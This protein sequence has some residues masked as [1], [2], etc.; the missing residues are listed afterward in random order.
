MSRLSIIMPVLDEGEAIAAALDALADLRAL[1]AEVIVVDGG[2]RDATVQR[3]RL[4]A[5]QVLTAPRG[6]ASQMNAGAE[7]AAGD[8]LLFLHAD[9]RLPAE[10]DHLIL[11]GLERSGQA[12]G[13]FDVR[14]GGRS[15]LLAVVGWLMNTRSR[16][17]G[18]ATGDQAI[19]VKREAFRA[20]GGFPDIALME[21]IALC[22]RLKR[23]GRP[24]CLRQRA[25][26][27]GRRWEKNGVLT[28]VL[29]MWRLRLSYLFG[30]DPAA[31]ARRYGYG[32]GSD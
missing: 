9:T 19:F 13:R 22:Q 10:A 2:S 26:T 27:S 15:V 3:A 18:I 17:T 5:D 25:I 20:Q 32:G 4:R 31:L 8:V 14:I 21:D 29:L 6:R 11:D 7:K 28:T 30:A 1:G 12:W 23:V 16:L 24:L